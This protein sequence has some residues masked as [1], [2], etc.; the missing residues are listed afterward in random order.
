MIIRAK[1]PKKSRPIRRGSDCKTDGRSETRGDDG[2][3]L[4]HGSWKSKPNSATPSRQFSSFGS[5]VGILWSEVKAGASAPALDRD[6]AATAKNRARGPPSRHPCPT[7]RPGAGRQARCR[8]RTGTLR[9]RTR[10]QLLEPLDQALTAA[11]FPRASRRDAP[12][13]TAIARFSV[14]GRFHSIVKVAS[15]ALIKLEAK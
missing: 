11:R 14:G 9:L 10:L 13:L 8:L 12:V 5:G 1:S 2:S 15:V 7:I 4:G 3:E 6:T